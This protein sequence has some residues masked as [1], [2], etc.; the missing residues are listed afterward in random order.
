MRANATTPGKRFAAATLVSRMTVARRDSWRSWVDGSMLFGNA[1]LAGAGKAPLD[2]IEQLALVLL[3]RQHVM[4]APLEHRRGEGAI[5]MQR[6]GGDDA[7]FERQHLQHF[8]GTLRLVAAGRLA[9]GQHH[10]GFRG[11]DVDHLQRRAALAALVGAAQRFAVDR[12]HAGE[13]DP[14]GLGKRRHEPPE[15]LL[16]GLRVQS[17][18][19][20]AEGIVAGDAVLQPQELPQQLF[21]GRG[22]TAP[23]RSRSSPRTASRPAR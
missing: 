14:V 11:E 13:L 23:C 10:P 6:I 5:A 9:R 17:A 7:A 21:L 2:R 19:H 3:E 18:E 20:P 12:H 1:A 8:Q 15:M 16:E 4:A 22:Q